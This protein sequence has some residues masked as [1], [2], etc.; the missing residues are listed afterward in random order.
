[1]NNLK[2]E[3]LAILNAYIYMQIPCDNGE[4]LIDAINELERQ[5]ESYFKM[6]SSDAGSM[7]I[8][9]KKNI[10]KLIKENPK[11][12]KFLNEM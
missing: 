8:E 6:L 9:S 10:L 3:E 11:L 2:N 1:M 12:A 7:E 5:P 4:K